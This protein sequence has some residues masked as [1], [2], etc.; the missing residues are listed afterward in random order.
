[1]D[2][3]FWVWLSLLEKINAYE[4]NQLIGILG[5][6]YE[7]WQKEAKVFH[8]LPFMNQRIF[9]Q[10]LAKEYINKAEESV[11]HMK[12][13][14]L[15]SILDAE[16]PLL[17]KATYDPPPVLYIRGSL[18]S[19]APAIAVV[20]SRKATLYGIEATD[21]ISYELAQRGIVIVSGLARGIDTI[22]HK[23]ALKASGKTIAVLGNGIDCI[24]PPENAGLAEE[25]ECNGV[26]VS[27]YAPG[28]KPF[29]LNFPARNRII[30]GLC[31]G[32]VVVEAAMKSGSLITAGFSLEQ[33]R[34]VFSVPGNITS[35]SSRGTN[36]LIKEGA[37]IVTCA[38][39]IL[40]EIKYNK[41]N[42]GNDKW[43]MQQK[44]LLDS[45]SKEE[46]DIVKLLSNGHMHIDRL[47]CESSIDM[48]ELNSI[49]LGMELK[50]I[51]EQQPG[52]F[53]RLSS[54]VFRAADC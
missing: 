2:N 11:K 39:D 38:D 9:S 47:F 44:Q 30:S 50:G 52:K 48:A 54:W 24:Y 10:L 41:D 22:A 25:I 3:I 46:A 12:K 32:T 27:E 45:L 17:L 16:Y 19:D 40:E 4:K 20:G 43:Q 36:N 53:F 23:G 5:P 49:L 18:P 34:D 31:S 6:P 33:G 28:I 15:I 37:K 29:A 21:L 42:G 7:F 13:A 51:V 14:R 1:M 35:I 26:L 8:E